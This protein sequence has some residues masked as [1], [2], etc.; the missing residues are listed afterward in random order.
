MKGFNTTEYQS[1]ISI[2]GIRKVFATGILAEI[3]SIEFFNSNDHAEETHMTNTSNKYLRYYS[4]EAANSVR[5]HSKDY[6]V[7]YQRKYNEVPKHKH[8][9]APH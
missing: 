6:G 4:I 3:G 2:P 9:R 5:Q 7:Y 8:K 1:L